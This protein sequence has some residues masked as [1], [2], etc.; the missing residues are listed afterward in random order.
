MLVVPFCVVLAWMMG[1]P[2]DLNFNQFESTVLFLAVLLTIV[3]LQVGR[4]WGG[5][6][7]HTCVV[8][9]SIKQLQPQRDQSLLFWLQTGSPV[10][11]CGLPVPRDS[12]GRPFVCVFHGDFWS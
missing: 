8:H 3:T 7:R 11:V 9:T 10:L 5:G 1:Q 2:L 6:G 12:C 4:V